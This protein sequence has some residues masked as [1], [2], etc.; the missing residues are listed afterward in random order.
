[1]HATSSR[2]NTAGLLCGTFCA[3]VAIACM[4]VG[5]GRAAEHVV[6][7]GGPAIQSVID[8]AEPGDV[9]IVSGGLHAGPLQLDKAITL[10]GRDG[11]GVDG[12][13]S[14]SAIVLTAPGVRIE[15]L[16]VR[17][18]GE[19]V[20]A[21]DA[22]IYVAATA[23]DSVVNGND[24]SHCAFGIWVHQTSGVEI[25]DNEIESR[26]ELRT[27]DRGNGIHLFD[28]SRL[29]I[30][31]NTVRHARDGIYVSATEDS[32]IEGNTTSKVR[33]GIHYMYSYRN[34]VS[35]NV[36]NDNTIGLALMESHDLL[37]EENRAFRNKRNGLLFR[38]VEGTQVRRNHLEDNG[39][40][41][42]FFSSVGNV[43]EDNWIIGNEMGLKIWAGTKGNV[44]EGNVI[45]GNRQQ[46]FY[47]S[48]EDQIW[49]AE[50]R[51]NYW[52]DYLGWDQDGDGV[53]DR[54]H[55]VDSFTAN[56]LYKYPSATLLLRSPTLETLAHLSDLLPML[57]TPTVIDQAPLMEEPTP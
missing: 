35:R 31:G 14:G 40:G 28:A 21:S 19:D 20:G 41:M 50:G 47:V 15:G 2:R 49:G 53:G 7:P 26:E 34:T 8:A 36:A 24:L 22:C 9:V 4:H 56:L 46:V 54:P 13:G 37:V 1:M 25:V 11:G 6:E 43:I 42:F 5:E 18:S 3:T 16:R 32:L 57:R 39:N 10:R 12:G 51:G 45:R 33:Y 17:N 29:V 38:D 48:A 30:R 27:T 55:R 44:I 52:S 23:T